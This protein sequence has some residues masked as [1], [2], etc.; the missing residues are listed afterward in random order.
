[1][2][3]NIQCALGM[4][5][6][7]APTEACKVV[8]LA[9]GDIVGKGVGDVVGDIED[10]EAV[11]GDIEDNEAV[12]GDIEDNEAVVGDMVGDVLG[13]V[14]G[15]MVGD[16]VELDRGTRV[17]EVYALK[18]WSYLESLHAP[19]CPQLVSGAMSMNSPE[20]SIRMN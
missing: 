1:M 2:P 7:L 12:V 15:N 16:I 14:V 17:A 5:D 11:V 4:A 3:I 18:S 20:G 6:P 10:N 13:D 9:L 8:F 19:H